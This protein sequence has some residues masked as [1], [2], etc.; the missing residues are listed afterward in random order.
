MN[1]NLTLNP[2]RSDALDSNRRGELTAAQRQGFAHPL[3]QRNRNAL[4][5]AGA[6][7]VMAVF[8]GVF[9]APSLATVWRIAIVGVALGIASS[10]IL[11]VLTGGDKALGRD[12][13]H[14]RVEAV[15]GPITKEQESAMDVDSTSICILRIGDQRFIVTPKTFEA[16]PPTGRVRLYY[17]PA[18]RKVVN[19]EAFADETMSGAPRP[20]AEAIIGSWRNNFAKATFTPDGRVTASVMGRHSVGQWSVDTEERLHAEIAGRTEIA[21]ASVI[22][23]ELRITLTGRVVTLTREA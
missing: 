5:T 2:L 13:R 19:L 1:A 12:L 15:T 9:A 22:G 14:G 20:L 11:R 23:N 21:Q 8:G 6:L 7:V 4:V 10:L 3:R 17:L 16:A 18:S